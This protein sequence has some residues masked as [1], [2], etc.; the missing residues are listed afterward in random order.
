MGLQ[1]CKTF[2]DTFEN[3]KI[4]IPTIRLNN[5]SY[6]KN[7][8]SQVVNAYKLNAE[9]FKHTKVVK[10]LTDLVMTFIIDSR[11]TKAVQLH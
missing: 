5:K 11:S 9:N 2:E 7:C 1:L 4:K 6:I 3:K 8:K 10:R